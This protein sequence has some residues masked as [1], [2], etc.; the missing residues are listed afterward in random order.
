MITT[1]HTSHMNF[2]GFKENSMP[3]KS[4]SIYWT[5]NL[6]KLLHKYHFNGSPLGFTRK[7]LSALLTKNTMCHQRILPSGSELLQKMNG[8]CY[9]V[10]KLFNPV[11]FYF[12]S[13]TEI[14]D[15]SKMYCRRFV[16]NHRRLFV[17][18]HRIFNHLNLRK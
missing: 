9:P 5:S 8:F 12:P 16:V 15:A 13:K 10:V 17:V 2:D 18:N 3:D 1:S 11:F 6:H 7:P 14:Q 4:L